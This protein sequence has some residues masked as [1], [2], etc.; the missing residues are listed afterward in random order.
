MSANTLIL[1]M[2]DLAFREQLAGHYEAYTNEQACKIDE[3]LILGNHWMSGYGMSACS[4]YGYSLQSDSLEY[5][6]Q[7]QNMTIWV[8]VLLHFGDCRVAAYLHI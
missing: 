3:S 2:R 4:H 7:H 8:T 6:P 1:S 5:G